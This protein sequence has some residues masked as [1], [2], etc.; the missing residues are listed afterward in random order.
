MRECPNGHASAT[1]DYC[2]SCGAPLAREPSAANETSYE[3]L[4]RP[5]P[6]CSAEGTEDDTFCESC[7]YRFGDPI[8]FCDEKPSIWEIVITADRAQY[9]RNEPVG[10]PFPEGM[11]AFVVTLIADEVDIGRSDASGASGQRID[12]DDPAISH[13]HAILVRQADGAYAISDLGSTNGTRINDEVAPIDSDARRRLEDGDRV[14]LGAWT[15]LLIRASSAAPA[16]TFAQ[17]L[18]AEGEMR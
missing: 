10:A 15:V 11:S 18:P 4:T 2:D 7:G 12:L 1:D 5:C 14:C 9:E 6:V 16:L 17:D 3:Q 8:S 13:R